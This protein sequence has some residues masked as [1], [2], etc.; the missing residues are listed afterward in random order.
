MDIAPSNSGFHSAGL[1]FRQAVGRTPEKDPY[2][3]G[4]KPE[5]NQD[6]S[7]Q[8]VT[9]PELREIQQLA[10]RDREVRA[11]EQAHSSVGGQYTGSPSYQYQRG[12]NGV[13]Y[14]V[15]GHVSIDVSSVPGDPAA[16]LQKMMT[17]RRA[18]LAPQR[19]SP[20]DRAVAAKASQKAADARMELA[21]VRLEESYRQTPDQSEPGKVVDVSV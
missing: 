21:E 3:R 10:K 11:H 8:R 13:S 18:A 5:N 9:E 19:P 7:K 17:V 12:S 2:P 1:I 15:G 4:I 14:A 16:T 6:F 20:Q